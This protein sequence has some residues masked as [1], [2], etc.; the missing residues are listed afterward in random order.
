[1]T[2]P[3]TELDIQQKELCAVAVMRSILEDFLTEN[4]IAFDEAHQ[5]CYGIYCIL[6]I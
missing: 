5:R 2:L 6:R 1:M 3:T 4:G